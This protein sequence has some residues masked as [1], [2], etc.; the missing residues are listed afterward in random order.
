FVFSGFRI[1]LSANIQS[2]AFKQQTEMGLANAY[3]LARVR[4]EEIKNGTYVPLTR[5]RKRLAS[6]TN[7]PNTQVDVRFDV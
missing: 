4:Q 1:P 3:Y 6:A 2:P 5:R 7:D